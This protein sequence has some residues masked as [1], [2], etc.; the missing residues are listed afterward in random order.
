MTILLS[1]PWQSDYR[2]NYQE[3]LTDVSIIL[4]IYFVF[5]YY[6]SVMSCSFMFYEYLCQ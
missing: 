3:N 5:H 2:S 1:G 4:S 6:V